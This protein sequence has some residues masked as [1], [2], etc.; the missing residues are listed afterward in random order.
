MFNKK[1]I[2]DFSPRTSAPKVV[3]EP[4]QPAK[5]QLF[6]RAPPKPFVAQFI[7]SVITREEY[8]PPADVTTYAAV[9]L[10]ETIID[11]LP[12][13]SG[14]APTT[15]YASLSQPY[16]LLSGTKT[17]VGGGVTSIN[18]LSGAIQITPGLYTTVSQFGQEI[19]VNAPTL[20]LP[21]DADPP[22]CFG[23]ANRGL[24]IANS[25][26]V[27]AGTANNTANLALSQSGVTS[28]N[29]GLGGVTIAP[30]SNILISTIGSTI[31]I[32]ATGNTGRTGPTGMTG[33]TGATGPTGFTGMT[34][35][36]GSTGD[37]GFTGPTGSTGD[38]G[39]TGPTG[40]TGSTGFTGPTGSTGFTGPTGYT[41]FTGP[42]GSTGATGP[43]G[44]TGSTGSTGATGPTG[45]TGATGPTGSTGSIGATGSTGATGV[46]GPTGPTGPTG[47]TGPT[48][49]PGTA[50]NTG[51]TGPTG[52]TGPTGPAGTATNTGATG[53]TGPTGPPGTGP[54]GNTGPTGR[55]GPT[56]NTGS[57]GPPPT[58][59]QP[60][61]TYYVSKNGLDTNIGSSWAP[62]LTIGQAISVIPLVT[63]SSGVSY[64]IVVFS[65]KY[66][67]NLTLGN[68][69]IVIEGGG[70]QDS[71]Y[72]T[73]IVGN[74]TFTVTNT[75]GTYVNELQFKNIQ[76]LPAASVATAMI[77]CAPA[78]LTNLGSLIFNNV[79]FGES[80]GTGVGWISSSSTTS[81]QVRF[82][83]CRLST[84]IQA[85]TAS[86]LQFSGTSNVS[87]TGTYIEVDLAV[88]AIEMD[89]S[90]VLSITN[91][92]I[93]NVSVTAIAPTG[94][95]Y[96]NSTPTGGQ[97]HALGTNSFVC[98]SPSSGGQA[99][100]V[101]AQTGQVTLLQNNG[102]AVKLGAP[103]DNC[104]TSGAGT[105]LTPVYYFG[106]SSLPTSAA[107]V[108]PITTTF[109]PLSLTSMPNNTLGGAFPVVSG[110]TQV[111]PIVGMTATGLINMT[112]IHPGGGGA[113]QYFQGIVY[114]ANQV[115]VTLG[116]SGAVGETITWSVIR[117][118]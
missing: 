39:F 25:A 110:A 2:P 21:T 87:I 31:T 109:V 56:G 36:T 43:T 116:S 37:T 62:F 50:S 55:T 101:I 65:G 58:L 44:S 45:S 71:V 61:L 66:V 9:P 79:K 54:T 32:S 117:F 111:I 73:T 11:S 93:Y 27:L 105:T 60:S 90:S 1:I 53:R 88:S 106:N 14:F 94:S 92:F 15:T 3:V 24:T 64:N 38:T 13:V 57:T 28:V 99:A 86:M 114:A 26:S 97:T 107:N 23:T 29:G 41:G 95:I 59:T 112:Y 34:G 5:P 10:P 30:G 35:P 78:A 46:T 113:S 17:G 102:F 84:N 63:V 80:T 42:T 103:T 81:Y 16:F 12:V 74:H 96:L 8:I 83:D 18:D 6:S 69:N 75:L 70:T 91:C 22:T 68:R 118:S 40:S 104:V 100:I 47:Q 7:P 72:N 49:A 77:A 115:T 52:I 76:L 4:I 19:R 98:A 85:F 108:G 20:G 33:S 82:Y 51:A 67:E 89:G 48:G